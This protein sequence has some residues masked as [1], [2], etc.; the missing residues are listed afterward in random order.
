MQWIDFPDTRFQIC[1]LN[2]FNETTPKLQRFPDRY[3][4]D[5][6]E[7]VFNIG[8]QT[9]G[10]RIRFQTDAATLSIRAQYPKFSP[11]TNMTQFTAQGIST[12]VNGRCWSARVPD[13]EGGEAE[14]SLFNDVPRAMRNIC[15]YLPLY[16]PI[17]ILS[18]GV[19]ENAKFEKPTPFALEKPIV[20]Y[21][22]SIT[23]GGCASRPGLSYQDMLGRKYNLDYLNFGF[24]GRGKCE[25]EVADILTETDPSCFVID[26]GQNNSLEELQERYRPFIDILRQKHPNIPLLATTPIFY[27]AELWSQTHIQTITKKRQTISDAIWD[28]MGE[29]DLNLHLLEAKDYLSDAFTDG[30][31]DGGHPND[32]GFA[33]MADAMGKKLAQILNLNPQS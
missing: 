26:V 3:E 8:K 12:Y 25:P 10:V 17:D 21:G 23:Q 6:P 2:W 15:L 16:G 7:S 31:V 30:A 14:L 32:L 33:H 24:S 29:S 22:T 4:N 18:I 28:R 20:F 9:A 19:D 11:R 27:N 13:M 5:L 1:G